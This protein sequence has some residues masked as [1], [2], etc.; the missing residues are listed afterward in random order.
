MTANDFRVWPGGLLPQHLQRPELQQV[1][2]LGVDWKDARD[3]VVEFERRVAE[4]AGSREAVAVDCCTH[5][6]FLA[7]RC[8]GAQGPVE[9]PRHTY[10]SVPMYIRH[11]GCAV[12]WRDEAWSG[13]YQLRPWPIWDGATRWRRG[14]Y[15]GGMHVV[16]FQIKKR[17]P[18]GRG[19]MILLDDPEQ[20]A[21]LRRAR[22]D[23]RDLD[24]TQWEDDPDFEGWHMYMTPEDAARG[25]LLM[26]QTADDLPDLGAWNNYADISAKRLFQE[27]T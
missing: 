15:Q 26:S 3:I 22:H 4:F 17:I 13:V 20:A 9:I 23:G 7:L 5:G 14:M 24:R 1:R 2:A 12:A 18:I 25:I 16:S 8:L 27:T 11:A 10:Q 21:W 19:G 6:L